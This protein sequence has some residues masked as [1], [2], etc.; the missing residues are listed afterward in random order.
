MSNFNIKRIRYSNHYY[1]DR[2]YIATK[3]FY[4]LL[5]LMYYDKNSNSKI[6]ASY[7]LIISKF[8]NNY[9]IVLNSLRNIITSKNSIKLNNITITLDFEEGLIQVVNKV[10]PELRIVGCLFHYIK[11]IRLNLGK[12]GL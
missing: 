5:I 6:P 9:I 3:E 11:Q 1:L 8:E 10:F 7:I 12:C 4:Q 2:T